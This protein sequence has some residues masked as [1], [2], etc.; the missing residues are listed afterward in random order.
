MISHFR[1][2]ITTAALGAL[3]V[4]A[5]QAQ[6]PLFNDKEVPKTQEDLLEIQNALQA[7]LEKS[8]EATVSITD[9]KGSGTGVI[10]SEDGIILTA[11]HVSAGV[12]KDL[13][14]ILR[15]GTKV[16]ARALGLD[17]RTD[18]AIIKIVNEDGKKYPFVTYDK[19]MRRDGIYRSSTKLGDWVYSLGHSGGF[20]KERDSVVRLGRIVRVNDDTST[21]Q[22]DCKL[23]GGDSGGPLFNL[24]GQLVGI[25]S[26]VGKVLDQNM[27]V[28]IDDW[29]KKDA[30]DESI[31]KELRTQTKWQRMMNNEFIGEG[32]FAKKPVKGAGFIGIAVEEVGGG[33]KITDVDESAAAGKAGLKIGDVIIKVNG[34]AIAKRADMAAMMK[35]AAQ[36][37]DFEFVIKRGEEEKTIK[38]QAGVR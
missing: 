30:N 38:L 23:I 21:F 24:S 16:K 31:S 17:S 3:L 1:K 12:K 6:R 33:L 36:G 8:R 37:D 14:V 2:T 4:G 10:V 27:H 15:D 28:Q 5:V 20:D 35:E 26:R 29:F 32:P 34:K 25:H 22:S 9:G 18:A 13:T 11:A 7:H 19:P